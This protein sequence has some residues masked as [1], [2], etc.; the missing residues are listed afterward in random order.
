MQLDQT[1][2]KSRF[3][4]SSS[5]DTSDLCICLVTYL[6]TYT[7]RLGGCLFTFL[8]LIGLSDVLIDSAIDLNLYYDDTYFSFTLNFIQTAKWTSVTD[9]KFCLFFSSSSFSILSV[10]FSFSSTFS[11]LQ[12]DQRVSMLV[13]SVQW[14]NRLSSKTT[15]VYPKVQ[16]IDDHTSILNSSTLDLPDAVDRFIRTLRNNKKIIKK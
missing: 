13:Y 4:A 10:R 6:Y 8:V 15:T 7:I 11:T 12:I 5:C 16:T 2:V 3:I 9:F 1:F 14:K